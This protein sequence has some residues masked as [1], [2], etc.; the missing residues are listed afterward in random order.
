M[1][2][3]FISEFLKGKVDPQ[4]I[5][6]YFKEIEENKIKFKNILRCKVSLYTNSTLNLE[7]FSYKIFDPNNTGGLLSRLIASQHYY[8]IDVPMKHDLYLYNKYL[9]KYKYPHNMVYAN[10]NFSYNKNSE[11]TF[12]K[13][14]ESKYSNQ[15]YI[16]YQREFL[17]IDNQVVRTPLS[18]PY[19]INVLNK[20]GLYFNDI[21]I[22]S[23]DNG[24]KKLNKIEKNFAVKNTVVYFYKMIEQK[25]S[26]SFK[27]NKNEIKSQF[28][29]QNGADS[30][31][32]KANISFPNLFNTLNTNKSTYTLS[33]IK[34]YITNKDNKVVIISYRD[35]KL[36]V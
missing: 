17:T 4:K 9:S 31:F 29:L 11:P 8:N 18:Q 12:T 2:Y 26:F 6:Y 13:T 27:D 22:K 24:E 5:E 33:L 23:I 34:S 10:Y 36:L 7:Y 3:A 21:R 20:D 14:L 16:A 35:L 25:N 28:N 15:L 30:M 19:V 32:N 1:T